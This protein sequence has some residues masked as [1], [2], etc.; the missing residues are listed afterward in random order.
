MS[1]SITA[2]ALENILPPLSSR[3]FVAH[4]YEIKDIAG[5]ETTRRTIVEIYLWKPSTKH[6]CVLLFNQRFWI[7]FTIHVYPPAYPCHGCPKP[8]DILTINFQLF[9]IFF[10][11]VT[12]EH[13]IKRNMAVEG[14]EQNWNKG[15]LTI[16]RLNESL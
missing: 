9:F 12:F 4:F 8:N 14:K 11:L 2:T 6:I 10:C 16:L 7:N 5:K 13:N 1:S 15:T 3:K